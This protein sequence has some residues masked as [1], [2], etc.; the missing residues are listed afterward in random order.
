MTTQILQNT[1][2]WNLQEEWS[3]LILP[4]VIFQLVLFPFLSNFEAVVFRIFMYLSEIFL[5]NCSST[6]RGEVSRCVPNLC[7]IKK[8]RIFYH[9]INVKSIYSSYY[10]CMIPSS[11][12]LNHRLLQSSQCTFMPVLS[13]TVR[14]C[15]CSF[16][17]SF[18]TS[19]LESAV[20]EPHFSLA[21]CCIC[22]RFCLFSEGHI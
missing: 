21:L 1:F 9:N 13:D 15:S 12:S 4:E 2:S 20:R 17:E 8:N 16:E 22:A 3:Q 6:L 18:C 19:N 10:I 7:G 5:K 14:C 11:S